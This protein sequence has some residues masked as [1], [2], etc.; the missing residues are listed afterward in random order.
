MAEISAISEKWSQRKRLPKRKHA[1]P[2]QNTPLWFRTNRL[3]MMFKIPSI[4][5]TNNDTFMKKNYKSPILIKEDP[6]NVNMIFCHAKSK[7][8]L[9][10]QSRKND[11]SQLQTQG[12]VWRQCQKLSKSIDRRKNQ[13]TDKPTPW[14]SVP[15]LKSHPS[16]NAHM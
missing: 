3:H 12:I 10:T 8:Q 11:K 2:T 6:L 9:Q 16:T 13:H 15:E 14:S 7:P 5:S 4:I 1:G